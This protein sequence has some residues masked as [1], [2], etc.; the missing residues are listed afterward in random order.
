MDRVRMR[1]LGVVAAKWGENPHRRRG[2]GSSA[3]FV[4]RGLVGPNMSLNRGRGKGSGLIFPH[5][6]S[7]CPSRDAS[8]QAERARQHAQVWKS[9]E[10]R[11]GENRMKARAGGVQAPLRPILG[12]R[13]KRDGVNLC[14]R[15]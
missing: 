15:T 14:V 12:A 2:Q 11:Y 1:I 10:S 6:A 9:G 5:R 3:M 4:S 7:L 13:E 8:R